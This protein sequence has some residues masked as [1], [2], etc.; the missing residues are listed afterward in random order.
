MTPADSPETEMMPLRVAGIEQI[1][2]GIF[3]F[4][5]QHPD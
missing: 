3:S 4:E 1:A 5:L 2:E